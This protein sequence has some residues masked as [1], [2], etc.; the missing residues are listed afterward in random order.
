MRVVAGDLRGRRLIAPVGHVTRPTTDQTREAVFNSL[1]SMDVVRDA[2]V[3]DL[4]AGSGA[5]GIEALSRGAAHVTFVE[6]DRAAL[7]VIKQNLNALGLVDRATVVPQDALF[8]L[9]DRRDSAP[10]DVAFV[11]PPYDFGEWPEILE[12]LRSALVVAETGR[13][14]VAGVGWQVTKAKRYGRAHIAFLEPVDG[15]S[16]DPAGDGEQTRPDTVHPLP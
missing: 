11:D 12:R 14:F 7:A 8:W 15:T 3:L 5:L 1:G 6:R 13:P 9:R 10:F 16:T 4:F 2:R